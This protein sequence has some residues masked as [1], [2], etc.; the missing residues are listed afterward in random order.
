MSETLI[1]LSKHKQRSE[2]NSVGWL[3]VTRAAQDGLETP[4]KC[5]S[6]SHMLSSSKDLEQKVFRDEVRVVVEVLVD[7]Y[8]YAMMRSLVVAVVSIEV[9]LIY[10]VVLVSGVGQSGVVIYIYP[11]TYTCV[12]VCI[13]MFFLRSF[14]IIGYYKILNIVLC[15]IQYILAVHPFCT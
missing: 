11:Y 7:K 10:S 1:L 13:Y 3:A 15:A 5:P 14:F 2:F 4:G 6:N 8:L 9:W 12:S